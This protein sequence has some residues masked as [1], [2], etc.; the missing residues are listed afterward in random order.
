MQVDPSYAT[1]EEGVWLIM[2][3]KFVFFSPHEV[4]DKPSSIVTV[5]RRIWDVYS[6]LLRFVTAKAGTV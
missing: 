2:S 4:T 3:V 6:G 5:R 1:K